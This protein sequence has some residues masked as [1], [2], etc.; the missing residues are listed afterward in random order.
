MSNQNFRYTELAAKARTNA[1]NEVRDFADAELT[2]YQAQLEE[3]KAESYKEAI[4]DMA[5]GRKTNAI[6]H[7]LNEATAFKG[8]TDDDLGLITFLQKDTF[9][10]LESGELIATSAAQPERQVLDFDQYQGDWFN[11]YTAESEDFT[12]EVIKMHA[13]RT[14]TIQQHNKNDPLADKKPE[15]VGSVGHAMRLLQERHTAHLKTKAE[16]VEAA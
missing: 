9:E 12:Y 11:K 3:A 14:F 8:I 5:L 6:I 16:Q 13:E 10:F 1:M 7:S 4:D 2:K 15:E